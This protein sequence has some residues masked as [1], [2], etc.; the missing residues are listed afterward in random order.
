MWESYRRRTE[1]KGDGMTNALAGRTALVT[2]STS[3][4]GEAIARLFAREGARVIVTGRREALGEAIVGEI[5][6]QGGEARYCR[7]D[8]KRAE[9]IERLVAFV[10]EAYGEIDIL[11]NNAYGGT[12]WRPLVELEEADWEA[13]I[14]SSLLAIYRMCKLV[15]PSMMRAGGGA[16]VNMSS[17]HGFTV[18][19]GAAVYNTVKAGVIN[20]T[21]QLALEY[22]PHG[23]RVNAICPGYIVRPRDVGNAPR[24]KT[25]TTPLIYPL[26]R[27]GRP[28]EV[29]QAA[30][31]LASEASSFVTGHALVVDGGI[32]IQNHETLM[33]PL[34]AHFRRTLAREWGVAAD[35]PSAL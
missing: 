24:L 21:R 13:G 35:E 8:I 22:G 30:L 29:A 15:I 1:R 28:D 18:G 31:F 26:G 4:L 25:E 14:S 11:V 3:G 20:L 2:G 5:T 27:A 7:A 17:I 34:A 12:R 19:H 10:R 9:E 6:S 23:I 16:I 33:A 32:T